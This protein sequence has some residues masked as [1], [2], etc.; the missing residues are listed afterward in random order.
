MKKKIR[1]I[2]AIFCFAIT[3]G[4]IK[5]VSRLRLDKIR[6]VFEMKCSLDSSEYFI[7]PLNI[8]RDKFNIEEIRAELTK[9]V[10]QTVDKFKEIYR[11]R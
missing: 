7:V 8:M 6:N 11:L 4:K 5:K 3:P 10:N 1:N 2:N 9:G